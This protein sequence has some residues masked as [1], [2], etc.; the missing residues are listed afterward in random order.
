MSAKD[1]DGLLRPL[2]VMVFLSGLYLVLLLV[3]AIS[4]VIGIFGIRFG[5]AIGGDDPMRGLPISTGFGLVAVAGTWC[6]ARAAWQSLKAKPMRVMALKVSHAEA[7]GIWELISSV[8]RRLNMRPPANLILGFDAA[9]FVTDGIV[10]TYDV[11]LTGRTLCISAPMLHV[12]TP[13]EFES[14]LAHE[15]AHFTGNDTLYSHYFYP[16]YR[17]SIHAL[18]QLQELA[19]ENEWYQFVMALPT[20]LVTGYLQ[21]FGSVEKNISRARELRADAV[22]AEVAGQNV[23]AQ[24]LAKAYAYG[25]LDRVTYNWMVGWLKENNAFLNVP[26]FFVEYMQHNHALLVETL[27]AAAPM[28]HPLNSHPGFL[29]RIHALGIQ[30]M[31]GQLT[32]QGQSAASLFPELEPMEERLTELRTLE[33]MNTRPGHFFTKKKQPDLD[34]MTI[35]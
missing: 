20:L 21:L 2:V 8:S 22:A 4:V 7:A 3:A 33:I 30:G 35:D 6:A 23:T 26:A 27:Q 13:A 12:L 18:H 1:Y 17:G 5:M 19:H 25:P 29:E 11:T 24:A 16:V 31:E 10:H 32:L 34:L 14:V 9:I 15:L 28:T